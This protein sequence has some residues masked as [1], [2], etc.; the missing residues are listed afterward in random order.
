MLPK[1]RRGRPPGRPPGRPSKY[2]PEVVDALLERIEKGGTFADASASVGVAYET[3]IGWRNRYADFDERVLAAEAK[4]K[5]ARID[6]IS[7]AGAKGNWTADAWYLERRYPEEYGKR[8][9]IQ[10]TDEQLTLLRKLGL[11]PNEAWNSLVKSLMAE[12]GRR[13]EEE[14]QFRVIEGRAYPPRAQI[15]ASVEGDP[16]DL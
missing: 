15:E 13:E 11:T 12:L 10:V 8:L 5:L 16:T 14:D 9:L 3:F 1:P 7:D 4:G 6:R 2:V